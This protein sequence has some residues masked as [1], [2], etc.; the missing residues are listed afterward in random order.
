FNLRKLK[1]V[2]FSALIFLKEMRKNKIRK[3]KVKQWILLALRTLI[4]LCIVAAFA[5]PALQGVRIGGTASAAKTSAV[6]ILDNTYSMSAVETYG[7]RFNK[8]KQTIKN[9]MDEFQEGDEYSLILTGEN[10]QEPFFT[11]GAGEFS[12]AVEESSITY[13]S[14]TLNPAVAK[15]ADILARSKNFNKEIYILSDFQKTRLAKAN[16]ELSNL[17]EYL[18]ENVKVFMFNYSG[19]DIYNLG[20]SNLKPDNQIFEKGSEAGFTASITNYAEQPAYNAVVSLFIN[21]ERSAQQS[22]NLNPGETKKVNFQTALKN[23]GYVEVFAELEDDEILYDN[24]YYS[25]IYVP[26][27]IKLLIAA[28]SPEDYKFLEPALLASG[29]G[30]FEITKRGYNQLAAL[31]PNNFDALIYFTNK[32]INGAQ[33]IKEYVENGGSIFIMPGAN[34]QLQ[35]YNNFMAKLGEPQAAGAAGNKEN[36][37]NY[38]LFD[39]VDF[40]HPVFQGIF[41]QGKKRSIDSPELYYYFKQQPQGKGKSIISLI[42]NTS[43]LTEF[44]LGKGKVLAL[45]SSPALEWNNMPLKGIFAPLMN[46]SVSYLATREGL[47]EDIR[48]G[49]EAVINLGSAVMPQARVER[50]DHT[51]D[52]INLASSSANR[53]ITYGRTDEAGAYKIKSR[54]ETVN[55][56]AVNIEPLESNT[57]SLSSGELDEYFQKIGFKGRKF[58]IEP[59]ANYS[60]TIQQAR[61]GSELWKLFLML[62]LI[63]ALIEMALARN[64]KAEMAEI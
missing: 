54:S 64:V 43:L 56:F 46:K 24:K 47:S 21:G 31:N 5:R 45:S 1:K 57:V 11:S 18:S 26:D 2:E 27:K 53:Y 49:E 63:L 42:D 4:I 37:S 13:A 19:R 62:G 36:R 12:K 9:I 22:I 20:V 6:F 35:D 39:K 41:E 28:G 58:L 61:F 16:E 48:A 25:S 55:M 34:S 38:G 59:D 23:A 32:D 10:N 3:I 44:V 14:G 60:N 8:A 7:S 29:G 33:R 51:E 30:R 40:E 52:I 50:P 15:A 17:G